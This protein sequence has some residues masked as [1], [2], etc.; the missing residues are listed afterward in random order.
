MSCGIGSRRARPL[1][2]RVED[3]IGGRLRPCD[4]RPIGEPQDNPP[5]GDQLRVALPIAFEVLA[6]TTW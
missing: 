6:L 5:G 2:N 3:S 1:G 4:D